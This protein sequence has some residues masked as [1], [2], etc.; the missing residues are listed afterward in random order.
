MDLV[1]EEGFCGPSQQDTDTTVSD[2][3]D[4]ENEE[5]AW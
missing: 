3:W 4:K 1:M 5:E 2:P